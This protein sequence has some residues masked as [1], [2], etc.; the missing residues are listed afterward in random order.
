[1][2]RIWLKNSRTGELIETSSEKEA[3]RFIEVGGSNP[4]NWS[5]VA[6]RKDHSSYVEKSKAKPKSKKESK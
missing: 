5:R 6:G 2:G 3:R 4:S 1:M